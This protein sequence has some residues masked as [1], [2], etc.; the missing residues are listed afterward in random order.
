MEFS[1]AEAAPWP[2]QPDRELGAPHRHD[3]WSE[4]R[5]LG[6]QDKRQENG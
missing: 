4:R 5:V 6:G 1:E 2:A 3:H